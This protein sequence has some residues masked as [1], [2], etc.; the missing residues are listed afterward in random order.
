[1][2]LL[3][4]TNN[5]GKIEKIKSS[6]KDLPCEIVTSQDLGLGLIDIE[7]TGKTL[8]EN[9]RLKAR[10]FFEAVKQAGLSDIAV[11]S[12]DGG[13]E[14]DALNGEPGIYAKRWAGEDATDDQIIAYALKRLEGV[15]REKRTAHFNVYQVIILPNG[16]ERVVT[17]TTNGWIVEESRKNKIPGLPYSGIL[18][19]EPYGKVLDD[20]SPE[21]F[22]TTHRTTALK[23]AQEVIEEYVRGES[24]S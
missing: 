20:L 1:M 11:L 13:I 17:G 14:I 18:V 23:Q 3:L 9:A 19:V 16:N 15:P 10:G 21:E 7:E 12:D 4:A 2:R 22:S 5:Q 24:E 6:L 8:E